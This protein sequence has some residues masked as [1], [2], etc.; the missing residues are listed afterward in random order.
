MVIMKNTGGITSEDI[1]RVKERRQIE[2]LRLEKSL[3]KKI[4]LFPHLLEQPVIKV[5]LHDH[6]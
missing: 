2:H 1:V 6:E 5:S 3:L 4:A